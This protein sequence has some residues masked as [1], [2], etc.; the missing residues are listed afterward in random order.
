MLTLT[1]RNLW[2][3]PT[4]GGIW[5]FAFWFFLLAGAVNY[6]NNLGF[7]MVFLIAAVDLV[8]IG[9]SFR[10]LDGQRVTVL[11]NQWLFANTPG[12]LELEANGT[13]KTNQLAIALDGQHRVS[14]DKTTNRFFLPWTPG[15][16]GLHPLP[17]LEVGSLFPFGWLHVR[18]KWKNPGQVWVFPEPIDAPTPKPVPG[19]GEQYGIEGEP[20]LRDYQAGDPLKRVQWKR[21]NPHQPWPVLMP[22]SRGQRDELDYR[23]YPDASWELCL[24]FLTAEVLKRRQS[25]DLFSLRLPDQTLGPDTGEAF[26]RLCLEALAKQGSTP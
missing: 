5:M 1:R 13:R 22:M 21:V 7:L 15:H 6:Q 26:T 2:L 9:I 4:A 18:H 19:D 17:V 24:S 25:G 20:N 11:T 16:R 14:T 12:E 10:N 23:A 8:S 3:V